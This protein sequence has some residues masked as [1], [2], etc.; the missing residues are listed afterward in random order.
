MHNKKR[1]YL[2]KRV[3]EVSK[4]YFLS[5]GIILGLLGI[6]S[7]RQNNLQ[8]IR[9]LNTLIA[10]DK[11]DGDTVTALNNLRTYIYGHMNTDPAS[12]TNAIRPPIQLKYTYDRLVAIEQKKADQANVGVY[13]GAQ[14]VCEQRAAAGDSGAGFSCVANYVTENG[15]K[16]KPVPDSLYKFDFLS[17]VWTFDMAGI[18]LVLSALFMIMFIIRLALEKWLLYRLG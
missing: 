15:V 1:Y 16:P 7:L 18:S 17:P 13:A 8:M 11:E 6:Y 14:A 4:Y 10:A 3:R 12:S 5:A 2:L 9:L